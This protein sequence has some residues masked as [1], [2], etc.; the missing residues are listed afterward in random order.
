MDCIVHGV[1]KSQ[2]RLSDFHFHPTASPY[3]CR[4][5]ETDREIPSG[6]RFED[7]GRD[8]GEASTQ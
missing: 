8:R 7:G 4:E 2:T 1:A 3:K 6:R 5:G